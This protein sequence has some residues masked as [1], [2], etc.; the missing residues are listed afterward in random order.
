VAVVAVLF[1]TQ[2]KI[3]TAAL[4]EDIKCSECSSYQGLVIITIFNKLFGICP[5]PE[6]IIKLP[7][8]I[9]LEIPLIHMGTQ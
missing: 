8:K 3:V 5:A 7:P 6:K 1:C 2:R 4:G 9:N